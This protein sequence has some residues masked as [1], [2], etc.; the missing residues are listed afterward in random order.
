MNLSQAKIQLEKIIALYKNM[1]TD[2]QNIAAIER[3]LMLG[4]IRQLYETVSELPVKSH[5]LGSS[6][7]STPTPP[8]VVERP[9]PQPVVETPRPVPPPPPPVVVERPRVVAP[10]PEPPPVVV[11]RPKP[12]PVVEA[13]RPTP[14]PAPPKT[15]APNAEV[16]ALFEEERS[17]NDLS[18]RLSQTPIADLTKAFSLNEKLLTINELFFGNN[19]HFNAAV[20]EVNDIGSLSAA[21]GYLSEI[22]QRNNWAAT[23]DRKRQAKAFIKLVRRRYK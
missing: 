14:P 13:P 12:Q 8:P 2:E 7:A 21:L 16:A 20:K 1:S 18:D 19:E 9:R 6:K 10:P 23:D 15:S 5:A 11:E 17:S 4:Y 3:D 22:A